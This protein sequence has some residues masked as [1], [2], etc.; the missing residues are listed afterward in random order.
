MTKGSS[1]SSGSQSTSGGSGYTT[2]SSGTNSQVRARL[3]KKAFQDISHVFYSRA[4]TTALA[5]MAL[6]PRTKTPTITPIAMDLTITAI[7][8]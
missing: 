5:T 4:T 1:T 6:M 7:P 8:T 3:R 2:T